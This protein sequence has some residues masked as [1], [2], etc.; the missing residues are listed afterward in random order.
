MDAGE[1]G[2]KVRSWEGRADDGGGWKGEPQRQRGGCAVHV[3][4]EEQAT[5]PTSERGE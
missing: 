2:E 5:G 1:F 4:S 3:A